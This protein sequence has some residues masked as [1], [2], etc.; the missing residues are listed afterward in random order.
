MA[1]NYA[2][3]EVKKFLGKEPEEKI[4]NF[5]GLLEISLLPSVYQ[6]QGEKARDNQI[7]IYRD[8][9]KVLPQ[10]NFKGTDFSSIQ[11]Q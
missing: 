10:I 5:Y 8:L 11:N 9:S 4:S 6:L 1:S 2:F 3:E 7:V